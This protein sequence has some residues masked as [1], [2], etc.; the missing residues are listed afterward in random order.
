MNTA[1]N[2]PFRY[3][4]IIPTYNSG[5]LLE[6]TVRE[7]LTVCKPV[8]VVVDGSTDSSEAP[9]MLLAAEEPQLRL[10]IQK[11]NSGKGGAVLAG[12][13]FAAARGF[14]HAAVFDAD[15]Q[16]EA[17]DLEV[18]RQASANHPEAMILGEP[19]FGEEAPALRVNGRKFGNWWTNL[20]TLWGGIH[21][22]LFGFRVYPIVPSVEIL[23]SIRGGRRFDFD[24]QLAVRLYWRGVP[25]LNIPTRVYYR[26]RAEG[27]VSHFKYLSDNLLLF[28]I[29]AQLTLLAMLRLPRLLRFR[30]RS[31][32]K[33]ER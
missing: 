6:Q 23:R 33:W 14:T 8:I 19:V 11:E 28:R 9:L 12:M 5:M 3:C 27:G 24:T 7:V 13:E 15:G 20:E 31:A 32:L 4:V 18:F 25:P 1:S 17:K 26:E 10:I 21:D 16:H 22:S 29:H 30:L 2:L